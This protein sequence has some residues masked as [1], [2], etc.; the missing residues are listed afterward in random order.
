VP[1]AVTTLILPLVAPVGTVAV[2]WVDE[3]TV[4]L[5]AF[6]VLNRTAVAPVKFVPVMTTVVPTGPL[7]GLKDVTVGAG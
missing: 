5:V 7:V 2:I 3:F 4:K 6:V 1:P